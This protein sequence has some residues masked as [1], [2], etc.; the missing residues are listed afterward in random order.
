MCSLRGTRLAS[1]C[2]LSAWGICSVRT[3]TGPFRL[4][5]PYFAL[6]GLYLPDCLIEV[7]SEF[8]CEPVENTRKLLECFLGPLRIG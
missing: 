7:R 3:E 5:G 4:Q 2:R 1:A 8:G 6:Q